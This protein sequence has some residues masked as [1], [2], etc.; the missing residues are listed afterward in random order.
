MHLVIL[1]AQIRQAITSSSLSFSGAAG[2]LTLIPVCQQ[3]VGF[4]LTHCWQFLHIH[5][6]DMRVGFHLGVQLK[7]VTPEQVTEK[8]QFH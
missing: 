6:A 4:K 5:H 7:Q 3:L 8:E 2:C 1:F